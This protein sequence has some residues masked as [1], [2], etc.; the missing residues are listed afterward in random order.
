MFFAPNIG[1][2]FIPDG[3]IKPQDSC[4]HVFQKLMGYESFAEISES[5]LLFDRLNNSNLYSR[6]NSDLIDSFC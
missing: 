2:R 3:Y 1:V 4:S 5:A 6:K